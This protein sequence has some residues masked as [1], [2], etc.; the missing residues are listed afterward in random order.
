M[1][2]C[3]VAGTLPTVGVRAVPFAVAPFADVVEMAFVD[4][5]VLRPPERVVDL[6]DLVDLADFLEF[7]RTKEEVGPMDA[8][9]DM[10]GVCC[11]IASTRAIGGVLV[12]RGGCCSCS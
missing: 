2:F 5:G 10:G 1:A 11:T 6:V 8:E 4:V 7:S 3:I 9:D 12:G